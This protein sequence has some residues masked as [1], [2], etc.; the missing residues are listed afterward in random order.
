[1]NT[2]ILS[3]Y[4]AHPLW[5]ARA[6]RSSLL[7]LVSTV[8]VSFFVIS[9]PSAR[10]GGSGPIINWDSAM[11][12]AG[13]NNGNPE[14]P[15][16]EIVTVHGSLFSPGQ[17]V[18]LKLVSG[19]PL[20]N[21]Y[22]CDGVGYVLPN[23]VTATASGTFDATFKWPDSSSG[24][25]TTSGSWSICGIDS[26]TF[27]TVSKRDDGPFTVLSPNAPN[28][29][30]SASSV[31]PGSALTI[32]GQNWTPPQALSVFIDVCAD[33]SPGP[34]GSVAM[35]TVNSS[36]VNNGTFTTNT[37][38]PSTVKPGS[39]IVNVVSQNGVLD[40]N[41]NGNAQKLTIVAPASATP[42]P[43]TAAASPTA[44]PTATAQA[45]P[46]ASQ[47]AATTAT[48]TTIP[49]SSSSGGGGGSLLLPLIVGT[50]LL[51]ILALVIL[52]F[53]M[54]RRQRSRQQNPPNNPSPQGPPYTQ[55][56][57]SN[58][59]PQ[60]PPYAQ[61]PPQGQQWYN[62]AQPAVRACTRCGHPLAPNSSI[63]GYCGLNNSSRAPV[64]PGSPF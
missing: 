62:V 30:I 57:P 44:A 58:V 20:S 46:S 1:M 27:N 35:L 32:S 49:N 59:P 60:G 38:I 63:C 12:Y 18:K 34:N 11:I 48:S 6:A 37:T 56:P 43:T 22:A 23:A 31:A 16:G 15:V 17:Q 13:Q 29:A 26:N 8:I 53:F 5:R 7:I 39:Y 61:N 24:V 25:I 40:A 45:T 52:L 47:T 10:A 4:A 2:R 14:G 42:T 51:I 3:W 41:Q 9:S 36:G 21:P 19:D 33:C 64:P 54:L 55:N 28:I 50:L